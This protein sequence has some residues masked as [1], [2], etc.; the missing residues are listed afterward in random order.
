MDPAFQPINGIS[1]ERYAELGAAIDGLD[2]AGIT[3]V[4]QEQGVGMSDWEAAKVGWTARMQ[5]MSLM[6]KVATAYMPL[7]QAALANRKGGAARISYEDFVLVSAAVKVWGFEAAVQACG[8]SQSDWTEAAGYWNQQMAANMMQYGGHH[9]LVSQEEA[10]LRAPGGTPRQVTVTRDASATGA[11]AGAAAAAA[12][13]ANPYAGAMG[14][15][16]AAAAQGNPMQQAMAAAMANPAMQQAQAAQAGIMKNPIGHA[17]NV[18][19]NALTGGITP[20]SNVN[21]EWSDGNR[22]PGKVINLSP[23]QVL[24]QFDNGSQQWCPE[25]AVKKA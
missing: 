13:Q 8:V 20:G 16:G 24:V 6:G 7:Y 4:M 11:P 12:G 17:F 1:L 3:K 10:K 22:Y 19:G 14:A 2:D 23:G 25:H 5:D 15:P 18:A 9:G 21:V